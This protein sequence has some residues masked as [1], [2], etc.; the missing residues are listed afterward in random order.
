MSYLDMDNPALHL[1]HNNFENNARAAFSELRRDEAFS[2]VQ[3]VCD[4]DAGVAVVTTA[5]K[6]ILAASSPFFN[7]VLRG[8]PH[9][10]PLLYLKGIPQKH[11]AMLLDFIYI[12]E[13]NVMQEDLEA[14]LTAAIELKVQGLTPSSP[15]HPLEDLGVSLSDVQPVSSPVSQCSSP[16]IQITPDQLPSPSDK[17]SPNQQQSPAKSSPVSISD[18]LSPP[19]TSPAVALESQYI[20]SEADS[21]LVKTEPCDIPEEESESIPKL[22]DWSDLKNFVSRLANDQKGERVYSCKVCHQKGSTSYAL[23]KHVESWHFPHSFKHIC[24]FCQEERPTKQALVCH[25][26]KMHKAEKSEEFT[27]A[28]K[29]KSPNMEGKLKESEAEQALE[30]HKEEKVEEVLKDKEVNSWSD[31]KKYVIKMTDDD[32]GGF[33][34]QCT[35]CRHKGR[36]MDNM[37]K[38]V[39]CHHFRGAIKHTCN[40]C[41][42]D[43]DTKYALDYHN[44][45]Q[46]RAEKSEEFNQAK[47]VKFPSREGELNSWSDLNLYVIKLPSDESGLKLFQCT[48]CQFKGRQCYDMKKHV[49]SLHFRGALKH[50][51][52]LCDTDFDTKNALQYHN[53]T[54]HK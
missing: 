17:S 48:I 43:F 18:L 39:E 22:A 28:V 7:H 21:G 45:T 52:N 42:I 11:L 34:V 2:D 46:H 35:I 19:A 14:F 16:P 53:Q 6:V 5:H 51:C 29:V 30:S 38:H 20:D 13:V 1:A 24:K 31:L 44:Q 40:F 4:D 12:G 49:E 37:T 26:Y 10:K 47:E 36:K 3:L 15:L 54:K 25:I 50:T 32:E 41:N 8:L 33:K 23:Q 9:H 27:K